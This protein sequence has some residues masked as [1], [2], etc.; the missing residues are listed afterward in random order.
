[1]D[2]VNKIEY[3]LRDLGTRSVTLFPTRAQI[4]R[5][6]KNVNLKVS[7]TTARFADADG[8]K[9]ANIPLVWHK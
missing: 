8:D 2:S 5:D 1:M 3:K 4:Q 9:F 6:I 7:P